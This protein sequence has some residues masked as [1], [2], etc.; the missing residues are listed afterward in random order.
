MDEARSGRLA[1]LILNKICPVCVDRNVD[2]TCDRLAA[3]TCTLMKK[4]PA[5]AEAILQVK[6]DRIEPYIQAIRD[7]VCV[8]CEHR[9]PDAS[10]DWRDID[11]C[12]LDSYLPLV[13]EAVEEFFEWE[14]G[15]AY[16]A[17]RA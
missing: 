8:T 14:K 9:Y 7:T 2:G 1:T 17:A 6:S 11:R 12:L 3:G 13:V 10:C 4:L 5:A 15:P 16:P